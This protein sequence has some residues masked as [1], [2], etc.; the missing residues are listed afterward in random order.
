[1]DAK[2]EFE[3]LGKEEEE[4]TFTSFSHRDAWNLGTLIVE[5]SKNNPQPLG[6]EIYLNG[7]LIFRYF[8][9]G[10]TRDHEFWLARK[11]RTVML[12]EMSSL[13]LKY[14]AEENG[15][16]IIDW[17]LDPNDYFLGG[18]GYPIKIKNTGMI[19]LILATGTNDIDEH[20]SI[21]SAIREYQEKISSR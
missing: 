13:R 21:V 11:H 3:R 4:L 10:I 8:P 9:D 18:G 14:M 2:G 7:L 20:N 5:K 17:K 19:G 15:S 6:L 16:K 1:M 12:R